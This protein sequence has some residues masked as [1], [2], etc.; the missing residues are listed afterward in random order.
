[1]DRTIEG[2]EK[3]R[4]DLRRLELAELAAWGDYYRSADPDLAGR[5][6]FRLEQRDGALISAVAKADV[7]A[8]NRVVGLGLGT[9]PDEDDIGTLVEEYA[10]IGVRRFFVQPSPLCADAGLVERLQAGG[11]RHYNNWVKLERD[12]AEP[13]RIDTDLEV[14]EIGG[15]HAH[16]F[17][18]IVARCF[19]WPEELAGWASAPVGRA[20]W[21]HY[22]AFDGETPAATGAFFVA[23]ETAWIGF[24]A[25]LPEY[26]NRGA[27]RAL[28]ARRIE[29]ATRLGC[30]TLT[31]E[32]AEDTTQNR[33]V[34]LNNLLAAGFRVAYVRPNYIYVKATEGGG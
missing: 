21:R 33:S 20:G 32:A 19:Q 3:S 1:M 26:R 2:P 34:S 17:G 29:G 16:D 5:L 13:P 9:A 23:G 15:E 11:F 4:A 6:G 18:E 14:R 7:L 25:T 12:V 27:Q 24:A 22:L 31:A 10:R 8:L 30:R 28:L